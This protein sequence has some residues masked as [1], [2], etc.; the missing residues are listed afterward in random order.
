MEAN[1]KHFFENSLFVLTA[2]KLTAINFNFRQKLSNYLKYSFLFNFTSGLIVKA[3]FFSQTS[4][5]RQLSELTEERNFTVYK[6]SK[7]INRLLKL[8]GNFQVYFFYFLNSSSIS[9]LF[10][11]LKKVFVLSPVKLAGIII[12]EVSLFCAFLSF[13]FGK[14]MFFVDWIIYCLFLILGLAGLFCK[15]SWQD[16][17]NNSYI[18]KLIT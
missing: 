10:I 7:V 3:K 4:L 12:V 2:Y 9:S 1:I 18:I 5:L 6:E 15:A 17:K 13:M 11:L 16:I 8:A 14:D